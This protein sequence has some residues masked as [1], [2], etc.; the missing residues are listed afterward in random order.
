MARMSKMASGLVLVFGLAVAGVAGA[1]HALEPVET[2]E[3]LIARIRS[4]FAGRDLEAIAEL[5]NWQGAPPI[6]RRIVN[7]QINYGLGRPIRSVGLEPLPENALRE[8][9]ARGTLKANMPVTHRL[10]V[11]RIALVVRAKRSGEE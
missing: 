10:R 8:V 1:A 11:V 2:E 6:R 3:A 9:E 5:V 7:F 4:A